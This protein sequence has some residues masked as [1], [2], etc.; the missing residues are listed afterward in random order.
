MKRML[1]P[2]LVQQAASPV[3][4]KTLTVPAVRRCFHISCYLRDRI[5]IND[6]NGLILTDTTTGKSLITG[7]DA[8]HIGGTGIHSVNSKRELVYIDKQFN[9]NK[10]SLTKK[11]KETIIECGNSSWEV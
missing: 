6:W 10:Y 5:W 3:L 2:F 1:L 7:L 11:M 9:I 8:R 4:Q